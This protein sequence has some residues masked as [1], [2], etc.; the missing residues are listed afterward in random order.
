MTIDIRNFY[1]NTPLDHYEYMRMHISEIP[2]EIIDKYN[3]LEK[4]NDGWI[5]FRIK[6]AIYGLKKQGYYQTKC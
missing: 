4:V 6:M 3:L 1:I 2:Q 5:Y